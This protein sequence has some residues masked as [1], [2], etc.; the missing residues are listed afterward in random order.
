[1][2]QRELEQCH[3][4][5]EKLPF[6]Q[7]E[8]EKP[9][10]LFPLRRFPSEEVK[11]GLSVPL[12]PALR[13]EISKRHCDP[14]LRI[15]LG[16][17][18]QVDQ[19]LGQQIYTWAELMTILGILFSGEDRATIHRVTMAIW[20]HDYPLGQSVLAADVKSLNQDP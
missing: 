1:V 17:S 11:L 19:F 13:S 2:T 7:S 6:P 5:I 18:E 9:H 16:V 10:S 20:E 14:F 3:Q 8:E 12:L 4:N 15:P